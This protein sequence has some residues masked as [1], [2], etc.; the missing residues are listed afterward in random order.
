MA[1]RSKHREAPHIKELLR[2][3]KDVIVEWQRKAVQKKVC[4]S[5]FTRLLQQHWML[6]PQSPFR[7]LQRRP[8][9]QLQSRFLTLLQQLLP[10]QLSP[11]W[12]QLLRL[13][14]QPLS[15]CQKLRR[16]LTRRLLSHRHG[17]RARKLRQRLR[18]LQRCR[19]PCTSGYILR[20]CPF[21][22][23]QPDPRLTLSMVYYG[24][25]YK[26]SR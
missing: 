23:Q 17:R 25:V 1:A 21:H 2:S 12:K 4:V 10:R 7:K 5:S 13:Q 15:L 8:L 19:L 24:K 3:V 16:R 6:Q 11:R 9:R 18:Q 14:P 20:P 22:I 26:P